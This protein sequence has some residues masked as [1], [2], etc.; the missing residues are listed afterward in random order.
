V[1]AWTPA[2]RPSRVTRCAAGGCSR[3]S[4][5]APSTCPPSLRP[6][7]HRGSV[8]AVERG[9]HVLH[10]GVGA[11]EG[12]AVLTAGFDRHRQVQTGDAAG[13]VD[14]RCPMLLINQHAAIAPFSGSTARDRPSKPAFCPPWSA[15]RVPGGWL[16]Q[17]VQ[18]AGETVAV[19]HGQDQQRSSSVAVGLSAE[20]FTVSLCGPASLK[21][22]HP[23]RH[24]SRRG[25]PRPCRYGR[26]RA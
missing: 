5:A 2:G 24:G 7:P 8:C 13:T 26:C 17:P 20:L 6:L 25:P 12:E 3:R 15:P 22:M 23:A 18:L 1:A 14:D 19:I 21:D 4:S 10:P 11:G 9:W 16:M